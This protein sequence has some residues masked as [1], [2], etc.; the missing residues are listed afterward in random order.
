MHRRIDDP[1]GALEKFPFLTYLFLARGKTRVVRRTYAGKYA[2]RRP[3]HTV[4]VSHLSMLANA[5]FDN[6]QRMPPVDLPQRKRNPEL[7]IIAL[8][9][10][11]YAVFGRK[12]LIQPF[13]NDGFSITARD[14]NH[15]DMKLAAMV[16]RKILQRP[17]GIRHEKQVGFWK[18]V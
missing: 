13:L 15:R 1:L 18:R 16:G 6:R 14:T 11:V 12:Q 4:Q 7:G 8:W 9:A 3:N 17:Q 5:R 10:T 2:Q